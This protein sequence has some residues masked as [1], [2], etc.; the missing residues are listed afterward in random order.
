MKLYPVDC[1]SC[2]LPF[3][4]LNT[5]ITK[6]MIQNKYNALTIEFRCHQCG[7]YGIIVESFDSDDRDVSISIHCVIKGENDEDN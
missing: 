3:D 4:E 7:S 6:T 5:V 1:L 2:G